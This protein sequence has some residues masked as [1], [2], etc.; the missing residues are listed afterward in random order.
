MYNSVKN[1]VVPD[2]V[3]IRSGKDSTN[4]TYWFRSARNIKNIYIGNQVVGL[5]NT[6]ANCCN[7]T[8]AVCGNNVINMEGT[9]YNCQNLTTAACGNNEWRI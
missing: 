5:A 3:K 9:Y 7:I 4:F 2:N 8:T 1:V 6:F